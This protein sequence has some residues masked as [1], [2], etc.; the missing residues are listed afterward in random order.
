MT[1]T[2]TNIGKEIMGRSYLIH[3][4]HVQAVFGR[5]DLAR[6]IAL[7]KGAQISATFEVQGKVVNV[8]ANS[9]KL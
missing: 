9:C 4:D 7:D 2:V 6:I 1:G 8:I 5:D 3:D